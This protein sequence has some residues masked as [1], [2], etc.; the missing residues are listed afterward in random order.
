MA[1]H[2]L[3]RHVRLDKNEVFYV[4][5]G[6]KYK[7]FSTLKTTE[8]ERGY[9]KSGRNPYWHR[10]VKKTEYRVEIILESEDYDFI[11]KKEVEFIAL[12]GRRDLCKGTLTNLTDGGEGIVGIIRTEEELKKRSERMKGEGN[13]NFGKYKDLHPSYGRKSSQETV[14]KLIEYRKNNLHPLAVLSLNLETGIFYDRTA[15]A[16][17]AHGLNV[18]T[19]QCYLNGTRKNT[20]S[21]VR[22]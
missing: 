14:D 13:P 20:T 22:V 6:T 7:P 18:N 4:G 3:Y 21:I 16:A 1:K 12:Y 8:Y 17:K 15:D 11:K 9:C 5:I 19:L 2:Y 10:I